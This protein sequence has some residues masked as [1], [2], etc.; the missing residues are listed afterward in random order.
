MERLR[1]DLHYDELNY[2]KGTLRRAAYDAFSQRSLSA[3]DALEVALIDHFGELYVH[4]Q[5]RYYKMMKNRWDFFVYYDG[6]YLG[7]DVFSTSRIPYI[8]RNVNHKLR[9]YADVPAHIPIYF[10][11]D[12]E[13]S[14]DDISS[15]VFLSGSLQAHQNITVI[16]LSAFLTYISTL[17]PLSSPPGVTLVLDKS[18]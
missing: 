8:L 5:K 1:H 11:V 6:G 10:V 9:K 2:T 18:I 3:E 15:A 14:D 17:K 16:S 7:I 4:T 12:G 13:M